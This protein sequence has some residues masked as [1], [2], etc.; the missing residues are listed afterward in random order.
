VKTTSNRMAATMVVLAVL[1]TACG[2][3]DSSDTTAAPAADT[4]AAAPAAGATIE[5]TS[6]DLGDYLVDEGG[7]TLY[8][9]L[10]DEQNSGS[11]ACEDQCLANWPPLEG[12]AAAGGGVD[13]GM[14]G[15]ITRSD[16]STQA[17]YNGWPLYY[18]A[19]DSA[20]G[21]T[22]GQSVNDVWYVI[23]PDGTVVEG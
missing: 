5:T 13:A 16:G 4:T 7:L 10:N 17:T 8:V 2:S 11:S 14:L 12:E 9:F 23:A 6:G 18:F 19:N 22:N 15:T 20:P 1:V 21:D 3:G